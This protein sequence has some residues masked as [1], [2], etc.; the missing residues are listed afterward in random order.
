LSQRYREANQGLRGKTVSYSNVADTMRYLASTTKGEECLHKV[1]LTSQFTSVGELFNIRYQIAWD[2]GPKVAL[3]CPSIEG[4]VTDEGMSAMNYPPVVLDPASSAMVG[5][6]QPT[7]YYQL[8][9][10]VTE[11]AARVTIAPPGQS[12]QL[13]CEPRVPGTV[14]YL[15]ES[16]RLEKALAESFAVNASQRTVRAAGYAPNFSSIPSANTSYRSLVDR[17]TM[18]FQ[19]VAACQASDDT[20]LPPPS[21]GDTPTVP[22]AKPADPTKL[23]PVDAPMEVGKPARSELGVFFDP[24]FPLMSETVRDCMRMAEHYRYKAFSQMETYERMYSILQKATEM[25]PPRAP[26]PTQ[27]MPAPAGTLPGNN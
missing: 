15:K 7:T 13:V 3:N 18:V 25:K 16:R 6:Y 24:D 11:T 4:L 19:R 2:G 8:Y 23:P 14:S 9:R 5:V 26:H 20:F 17:M 27:F 10:L 1:L 22:V 21:G 12:D